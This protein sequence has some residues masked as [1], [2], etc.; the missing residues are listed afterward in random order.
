MMKK[1]GND[2]TIKRPGDNIHENNNNTS[3]ASV[4]VIGVILIF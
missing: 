4:S 1:S 2:R 3:L